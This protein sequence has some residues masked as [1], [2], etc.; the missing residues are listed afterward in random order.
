MYYTW[1][2]AIQKQA[3]IVIQVFKVT[4]HCA[5]DTE[6]NPRYSGPRVADGVGAL[7]KLLERTL[8]VEAK[9]LRAL[10]CK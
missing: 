9:P 1:S 4:Q 7:Q 10:K 2:N 5:K 8:D 6:S 3:D